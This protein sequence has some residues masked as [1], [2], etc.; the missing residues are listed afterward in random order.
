MQNKPK[1][2][3]SNVISLLGPGHRRLKGNC[4]CHTTYSDGAHSPSEAV[5]KYREAGYDF[6]YITEHV[7]KLTYGKLPDFDLIDSADFRVLPGVEYRSLSIRN[8]QTFVE[9]IIGLN[10][11]ELS[12]WK[13]QMSDQDV[14]DMINDVGGFAIL[15]HPYWSGRTIEDMAKLNGLGG[16]EIYNSTVDNVNLKGYAVA[17]WEQL[18]D[19]R[20]HVYGLAVD[21]THDNNDRPSDFAQGW[22]VISADENTPQT[23]DNAMRNGYFYSSCGP[24]IHEWSLEENIMTFRCSEV[25]DIALSADGPRGQMF[26]DPNGQALVETQMDISWLL[27]D[28]DDTRYF[29]VSCRDKNGRW[30]WTNPIRLGD[31]RKTTGLMTGQQ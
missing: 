8:G 28:T 13:S 2:H 5:R 30:A 3:F 14:I 24:E 17:N 16:I 4:H 26:R 11:K 29:R 1:N 20:T 23:I 25:R 15:G 9:D 22:I 18:L 6:L 10:T 19:H 31:L 21:D 12:R 27:E 7:D